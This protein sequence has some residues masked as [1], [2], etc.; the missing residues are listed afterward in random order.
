V[1]LLECKTI[2]IDD[3]LTGIRENG[4]MIVRKM[5]AHLDRGETVILDC[6]H[7]LGVENKGKFNMIQMKNNMFVVVCDKCTQFALLGE[8]MAGEPTSMGCHGS[9]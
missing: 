5:V 9:A 1:G 4:D 8:T 2:P 3:V 7:P 6:T